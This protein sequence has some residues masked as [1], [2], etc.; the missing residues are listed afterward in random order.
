MS[1]D[2]AGRLRDELAAARAAG[3]HYE[4]AHALEG[5]EALDP[6]DP[7]WPH[8]LGDSLRILGRNEDAVAAWTRAV[9]RYVDQGFLARAV[10]MARTILYVDPSRTDVLERV[11]A[12]SPPPSRGF[13]MGAAV[14]A[15]A[16]IAAVPHAPLGAPEE[17]VAS[18]PPLVRAADAADDE[19]RFD[20][21]PHSV[22]IPFTNAE[23]APRSAP[24]S[25]VDIEV[26]ELDVHQLSALP[27]F[28]LFASVDRE[29]LQE[30]ALCS[31]LVERDDDGG[32][33]LQRGDPADALYAIVEGSVRVVP[34][35]VSPLAAPHL[36]EGDV[37]GESCLL[38]GGERGADVLVH[39]RLRALRIGRDLLARVTSTNPNV[40]SLLFELLTR[41]LVG[42]LVA[43]SELFG[44]FD[45]DT[46]RELARTFEA[47]RAGAGTVLLETGK[48][49]DA[50]Y[51]SLAGHLH[52]EGA[53]G[54]IDV[55]MPGAIFG[56]RSLLSGAPSE[57]TVRAETEVLVL[58]LPARGFNALAAQYP[59]ALAHLSEL[60]SRPVL[61]PEAIS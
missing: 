19:T 4:A 12:K 6:K 53:S 34:P 23:V 61:K 59:P 43:T 35:G 60:A 57:L 8:R 14:K 51:I 52:V 39:G 56:Q 37:F 41:R 49:S 25:V 47:R 45:P 38:S 17:A 22:D 15:P 36:R 5:L 18:A 33:V 28:P 16:E 44:A 11:E 48:R 55:A 21:A 58:R 9:D 26:E 29:V 20:D 30:I 54:E 7:R 31:E 10:A 32:V 13:T 3:Q 50:L 2:R 1:R 27:L 46:R 24:V 40:G 42:N